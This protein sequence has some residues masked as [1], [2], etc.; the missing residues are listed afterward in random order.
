MGAAA[1]AAA[2]VRVDTLR[3]AEAGLLELS[4]R[5]GKHN[6]NTNSEEEDDDVYTME[7]F[8]TT[9][10]VSVL[11]LK[12]EAPTPPPRSYWSYVNI[13]SSN[14][15]GTKHDKKEEDDDEEQFTMHALRVTKKKSREE[16]ENEHTYHQPYPLVIVHGYMNGAL[17]FYRNVRSL[18]HY[19]DSVVSVD[20][21]GWGLSSRPDYI[22]NIQDDTVQSSEEFFVD[23]LEYWRAANNI[24]KM[25]LAGHSMG[26]Y[27]SVAY[28]E[29]Y[30]QRVDRL[31]LLSP[32]GIPDDPPAAIAHRRAQFLTT[33]TRKAVYGL[34]GKLWEYGYTPGSVMRTLPEPRGRAL[35][36][37]YVRQRL[38]SIDKED[39]RSVL[40][41]YMYT[42]AILPGSGEYALNKLLW[43]GA[44][45]K[46]P[47]LHRIPHL[48]I[49]NISFLYGVHDWMD[50]KG[51][52]DVQTICNKNREEQQNTN[53][54]TTT[55]NNT[56]TASTT[57]IVPNIDVY[58]VRDAGHLLML[59][60]SVG[61][62]SAVIYACSNGCDSNLTSDQIP[63]IATRTKDDHHP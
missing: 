22:K 8:D 44:I 15:Y 2:Q 48:A 60:N 37:G 43:P 24:D 32:A 11:P 30:P 35:V 34:F 17:Y 10:P 50:V 1:V 54:S 58:Q 56:N 51:G 38:P 13:L 21:L 36:E 55:T 18:A 47:C 46:Q 6:G 28:C 14:N 25:V 23:S 41:E 40:A 45:A 9:I 62:N 5:F 63:I 3:Q 42:G 57:N 16:N 31:L 20:L 39:E 52:L 33:Y 61:F 26:G 19:F 4:R 59:E 12:R 27:L 53:N 29:K 7:V 49:A